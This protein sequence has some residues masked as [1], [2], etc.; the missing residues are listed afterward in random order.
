MLYFL[1]NFA[2]AIFI[3]DIFH[4]DILLLLFYPCLGKIYK[5]LCRGRP[6]KIWIFYSFEDFWSKCLCSFSFAKYIC[7]FSLQL[8]IFSDFV[9]WDPILLFCFVLLWVA[10]LSDFSGKVIWVFCFP[11][12]SSV[13]LYFSQLTSRW[14]HMST[15][16]F[17]V[18]QS[19]SKV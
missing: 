5:Q 6:F 9:F 17:E 14:I 11:L 15:W 13:S 18:W 8:S 3:I 4:L 1:L 7:G 12:L 19:I 2:N 16:H 10:F